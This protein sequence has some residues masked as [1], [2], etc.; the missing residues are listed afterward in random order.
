[1]AIRLGNS[2]SNC[3]SLLATQICKKHG[4]KVNSSY[5]CDNFEMK[6]ALKDDANC[7]TCARY[8]T[9]TCANPKK[10]APGMLCS[11]WAPLNATA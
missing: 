10:A 4:V 6:V 9:P 2:C 7:S 11:H 5:T 8:E 3:K 1:M